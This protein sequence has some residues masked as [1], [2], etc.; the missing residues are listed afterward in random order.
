MPRLSLEALIEALTPPAV[1]SLSHARSLCTMLATHTP[2]PRYAVL[3]PIIASLSSAESPPLLQAA[4]YEI[5]AAYWA[6]SGSAVLTTADRLSCLSLFFDPAVPWSLEVWEARFHALYAIIQSGAE[7]VEMESD[8]LKVLRSWIEGAFEGLTRREQPP[9][10]EEWR[11]RQSSVRQ[12]TD[13]LTTLVGKP[14]FVSRLSEEDTMEVLKLWQ[15]L[16]DRALSLPPE[17]FPSSSTPA[18]PINEGRAS[19]A[20]SPSRLPL[21]HRRNL[22]SLSIPQ[23]AAPRHPA[24]VA[25]EA[26]VT[27]L[28]TRLTALA[29]HYLQFILP[30]LFRCLAHYS[31]PL[32]RI[33]LETS[34]PCQDPLEKRVTDTLR[35]L[36][37]GPYSSSCTKLIKDFLLP[38]KT[39]SW[40]SAQTTV[41]ALRTLRVSIREALVNRLARAFITRETAMDYTPAG[42]P[43]RLDLEREAMARAWS[44]DEVA[45]WDLLKFRGVLCRAIKAW[46]ELPEDSEGL[47]TV[48]RE[49]VLTEAASIVKDVVQTLDIRDDEEEV[50]DEEVNAV[51]DILRALVAYVQHMT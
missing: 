31:T 21:A 35:N 48:A 30:L 22:S 32:P 12:L 37:S 44:Q 39:P 26:Y 3:S 5:L 42:V 19:K 45:S 23:T 14:E 7:T 51:G 25:T 50:D 6:H 38:P 16:I 36:V 15:R 34:P 8:L 40:T 18:S 10:Q 4:G 46:V 13:F 17:G 41:G 49:Q 24:D 47:S 43:T 27:Y 11:E 2:T 33:A 28:A 1:P 29:P 9:S 20:T